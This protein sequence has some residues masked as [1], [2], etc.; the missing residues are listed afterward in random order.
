MQQ[1]HQ[2][3]HINGIKLEIQHLVLIERFAECKI[4]HGD[5]GKLIIVQCVDCFLKIV[6][7]IQLAGGFYHQ[8]LILQIQLSD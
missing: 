6:R 3:A 8:S 5:A 4:I 2:P 1:I 7:H